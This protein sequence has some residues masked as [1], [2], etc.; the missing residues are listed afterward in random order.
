MPAKRGSKK[1]SDRDITPGTEAVPV[2]VHFALPGSL[3][4]KQQS[5]LHDST[6]TGA[7]LPQAKKK[8]KKKS[9]P[10]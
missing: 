3:Q 1:D 5:H 2:P 4:T 6:L 10:V 7:E 9:N 8:K